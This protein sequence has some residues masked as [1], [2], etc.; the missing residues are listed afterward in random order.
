M[1]KRLFFC[2]FMWGMCSGLSA[3]ILEGPLPFFRSFLDGNL[4]KITFPEPN[5]PGASG[6]DSKGNYKRKNRAAESVWGLQLTEGK[7]EI[8]A[9]YLPEY[10][11]STEDGLLIEFEYIMMYTNVGEAGVTDGICMFLVD[12][13]T[14]EYIGANLKYGAE[15]AGFGYTHRRSAHTDIRY[16]VTSITGIKGGYLAVALDQGHFKNWRFDNYEMRNGIPYG[17]A[18]IANI[19]SETY[20]TRSN[21]TIRGAAGRDEK[22]ITTSQKTHRIQDGRWGFPV[23]ITRHTGWNEKTG[24]E[25]PYSDGLRNKAGFR[26]NTQTGEYEQ[27]VTP[28][29]DKPFCIAGGK[30]FHHSGESAYRKAIIALEPNIVGGGFRITVTIQHETEKTVVIEDYTYPSSL[31]YTENGLPFQLVAGEYPTVVYYSNPPQTELALERPS[32]LVIGFMA[33]TGQ[34]TAYTNIIRNLRITPLYGASSEDDIYDHRRGPVIVRPLDNDVAYQLGGDRPNASYDN[35]D[36]TSFR[37]W[38]DEKHC[39]GNGVFEYEEEGVGKWKY[40]PE[41]GEMMFFP[42]KGVGGEVVIWYDVKGK[43]MPYAEEKYR[44]SLAKIVINLID[45]EG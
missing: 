5:E 18:G 33:S 11:F 9:F 32:K 41:S 17:S 12:A 40:D 15:G 3:Q 22:V 28:R 8:G 36:L 24:L 38:I 20:N 7:E 16:G 4:T 30:E 45:D 34:L 25:D 42:E 1:V 23:L 31:Q 6:W 2:L 43:H 35:L 19:Q 37:M 39:L 27:Y 13:T 29:I 26:L 21:V 44:S 14:N 10:I